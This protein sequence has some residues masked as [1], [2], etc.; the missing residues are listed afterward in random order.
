MPCEAE[1]EFALPCF[2]ILIVHSLKAYSIQG[3][4]TACEQIENEQSEQAANLSHNYATIHLT[5]M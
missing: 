4:R 1:K 2:D 5:V 3:K